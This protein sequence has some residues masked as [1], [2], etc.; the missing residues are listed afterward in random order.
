[1]VGQ[2]EL[3]SVST[4][5]D[6]I[7]C[8]LIIEHEAG[9]KVGSSIKSRSVF[10]IAKRGTHVETFELAI[11]C[12]PC[13][14]HELLSFTVDIIKPLLEETFELTVTNIF[15][16]VDYSIYQHGSVI[17]ILFNALEGNKE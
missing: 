9:D 8:R 17:T 15:E 16:I 5:N 1:V 7:W 14:Y 4:D 6:T 13:N 12:E 3:S 10:L 11:T 2:K